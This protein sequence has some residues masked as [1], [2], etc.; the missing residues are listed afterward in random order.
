[1]ID[2]PTYRLLETAVAALRQLADAADRANELTE[3]V[4]D[5]QAK[6]LAGMEQLQRSSQQLEL[7]LM[8][9]EDDYLV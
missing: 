8:E 9:P 7:I 6:S 5:N 1:M 3:I 4:L 2:N